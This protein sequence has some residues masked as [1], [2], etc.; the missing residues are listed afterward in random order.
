MKKYGDMTDADLDTWQILPGVAPVL[1]S[2][3]M[4][5]WL[6]RRDQR[7]DEQEKKTGRWEYYG[8]RNNIFD[9]AG[10]KTWGRAYRCNNC[11]F[12]HVAIENHGIYTYCPNCGARMEAKE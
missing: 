4:G 8:N 9:W 6:E 3:Q 7:R 5:A 11:G 12:I 10:V 1:I 2:R